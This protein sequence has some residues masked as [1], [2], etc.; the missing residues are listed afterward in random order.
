MG[1]AL[2]FLISPLARYLGIALAVLA[3][4]FGVHHH[5]FNKG[6]ARERAAEAARLERARKDVARRE[7]KAV[8]ITD[9]VARKSEAHQV[10]IRWRTIT[11]IRE[12][13]KYVTAETDRSYPIPV[14]LVRVHDAAARGLDPSAVPDPSGLPDDAPSGVTASALGAS[15]ASNYGSCLADLERFRDLQGWVSQQKAAWDAPSMR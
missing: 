7:A 1:A 9:D 4:L 10:E 2:A 8:Q 5:G 15:I 12:V 13:P 11:T 3:L 6:L 14:G